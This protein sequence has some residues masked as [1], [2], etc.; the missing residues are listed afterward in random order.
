MAYSVLFSNG[1]R[2]AKN[3]QTAPKTC[4]LIESFP[5]A[6]NCRRGS[7]K[8]AMVPSLSHASP[9]VGPTNTILQIV[10][11]LKVA[12]EVTIRVAEETK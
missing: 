6:A 8:V 12:D 2:D 11:G 4:A 5:E 9:Y 3:C 10:L 7:V 1:K